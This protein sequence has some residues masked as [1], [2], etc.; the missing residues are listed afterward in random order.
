M[1]E[2]PS[3]YKRMLECSAV[4]SSAVPCGK[5]FLCVLSLDKER[6]DSTEQTYTCG[7][8]SSCLLIHSVTFAL[9]PGHGLALRTNCCLYQ[10]GFRKLIKEKKNT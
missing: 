4:K 3:S 7:Q 9:L 10:R 5:N 8:K 1:R 2:A 6:G